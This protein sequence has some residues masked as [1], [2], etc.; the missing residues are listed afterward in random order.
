MAKGYKK[1][2]LGCGRKRDDDAVNLD[3]IA[4]PNVDVV[5]DLNVFPYP[6]K[7]GEFDEV[8]AED[9]LEHLDDVVKSMNEIWRIMKKGG[10][11]WIRGPSYTYPEDVWRDP[12]HKRAFS[13]HTFDNFDPST[14]DGMNY[15]FYCG[16]AQFKV[17]LVREENRGLEFTLIKI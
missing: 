1:L 12:T 5:H 11:L 13:P 7:D 15:G 3:I 4:M 9:V 8:K 10:K 16:P 2:V 14:W 6:F 17:E